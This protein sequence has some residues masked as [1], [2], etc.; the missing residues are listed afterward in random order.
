MA[1]RR[2]GGLRSTR[3]RGLRRSLESGLRRSLES[4][5]R[6]DLESGLRRG[7][8]GRLRIGRSHGLKTH[9]RSLGGSQRQFDGLPYDDLPDFLTLPEGASLAQALE[10]PA[11]RA[12]GQ[13]G[14]AT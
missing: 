4:G 10:K 9:D 7:L 14:M 11:G 5:L 13:L 1:T 3:G 8:E 12:P 2:R 6:R